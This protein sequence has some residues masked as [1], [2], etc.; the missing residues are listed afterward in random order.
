MSDEIGYQI[1]IELKEINKNLRK[2]A[3]DCVVHHW[4]DP[5]KVVLFPSVEEDEDEEMP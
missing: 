1:A 3:E 4:L 2:M 5:R